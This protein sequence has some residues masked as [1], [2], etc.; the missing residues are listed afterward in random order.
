MRDLIKVLLFGMV[1]LLAPYVSAE[2]YKV[3]IIPDNVVT[4]TAAVDSYIYDASAEFFADGV[5]NIL[6]QTDFIQVP[7][8]SD[9][10]NVLRSEPSSIVNAKNLTSKFK[11]SYN[12][13]YQQLKK[14]AQKT[15]TKYVLMLTS[16]IDAENYILRRTLWD[17]LNIA[18]ATV[19]DPAYKINTYAVLVD[20]D[21]NVV[22]WSDTFY[23][24]ISVCENR[25]ITRGPSPQTEQLEKIRDYSRLLCPQIAEKVQLSILPPDVYSRES[26]QVYY[27]GSN[28]DNIFTKKYRQW[29]K[30][31]NK[32]SKQAGSSIKKKRERSQ[33]KKRVKAEQVSDKQT[34]KST[35][36]TGKQAEPTKIIQPFD[37][38]ES[39]YEP[40]DIKRTRR[41]TLYGEYDAVRP[42]L[43]DYDKL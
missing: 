6:N 8:V 31:G 21:K 9:V 42:P 36:K 12:I 18:G 39:L 23:K 24:T 14:V 4:E 25:I 17:F 2:Q 20:T 22:V 37:I 38:D 33:E 27:D 34:V 41:N 28:I 30:D 1:I 32:L 5:V 35:V 15:Q 3:V 19:I 7:T 26:H 40:I 10:R 29:R 13:N 43:R 11:S 16:S